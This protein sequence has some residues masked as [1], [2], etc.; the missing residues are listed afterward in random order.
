M[1][2]PESA[3]DRLEGLCQGDTVHVTV[4]DS[5]G[6]STILGLRRVACRFSQCD[7]LLTY[8][9]G[10]WG[11][12]PRGNN[13]G[14]YL[15]DNFSS[16]FSAGLQIGCANT[17]T[18][19][20]AQ[21]VTDF[22]PSGSVA[23]V[24]PAGSLIDAINYKNIL[25]G[26]LV[27]AKLN[28]GF[29]LYDAAFST[30]SQNL[31]DQYFTGGAFSGVTLG[32][33]I[34]IADSVIGGCL[35]GYSLS[36]LNL[37]LTLANENYDNGTV[38]YGYLACVQPSLGARIRER[39]LGNDILVFPNPASNLINLAFNGEEGKAGVILITD[40][41]GKTLYEQKITAQEG[42]NTLR[43]PIDHIQSQHCL[44]SVRFPEKTKTVRL[45]IER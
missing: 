9:Q 7:T 2:Q 12:R 18:L 41:L 16:A 11:A 24:L 1:P 13:A 30:S 36:D 43:I 32:R 15:H 39:N 25:A 10:G 28:V 42:V 6:C 8:T 40:I 23:S 33:V 3:Q 5:R 4:T 34:E 37:A 44:I 17:F 20:T 22:L 19:T 35:S 31:R 38:S 26:Q 45:L 27:A 21:T 29:D 14:T